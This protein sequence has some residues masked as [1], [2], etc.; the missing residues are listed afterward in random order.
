MSTLNLLYS[1]RCTPVVPNR[2]VAN[3]ACRPRQVSTAALMCRA[4]AGELAGRL[5]L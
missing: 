3:V 5:P 2:S 1:V 4:L